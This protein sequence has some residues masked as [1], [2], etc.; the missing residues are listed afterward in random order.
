MVDNGTINSIIDLCANELVDL[1]IAPTKVSKSGMG[2]LRKDRLELAGKKG[3]PVIFT[4]GTLDG[5]F[6][7]LEDPR[8]KGRKTIKHVEDWFLVRINEEG[9]KKLG[10]VI[11][12]KAN[13]A[14]G[15]TAVVIPKH[16]FSANDKEG[17]PFYNPEGINVFTKSVKDNVKN[18]VEVLEVDS[19]IN[20]EKYANI[21]VDVLDRMTHSL[22]K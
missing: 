20:D 13:K 15:P 1:Y 18:S 2:K 5:A 21:V 4:P 22:V 9:L 7:P 19:Y 10:K 16:G 3:L 14:K 11:A 6:L 12:D 8:F 17:Q